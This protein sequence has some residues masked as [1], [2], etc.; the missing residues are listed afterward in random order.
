M[1]A[2]AAEKAGCTKS[3]G[4][5]L[6][7]PI[8]RIPRYLLLLKDL[9]AHT[10]E[11]HPDFN[12]LSVIFP[13]M[14]DVANYINN[15]KSKYDNLNSIYTISSRVCGYSDVSLPFSLFAC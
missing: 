7:T 8:Q 5:L 6:V 13:L 2:S 1:I 3:L 4:S 15:E 10:P 12:T 14:E 11:D 9:I